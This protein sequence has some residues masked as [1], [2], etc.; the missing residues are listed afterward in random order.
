V[1]ID[2]RKNADAIDR[3]V[4]R[5]GDRLK[6]YYETSQSE[7]AKVSKIIDDNFNA[8][9][10]LVIDDASHLYE[11]TKKALDVAFP[12]L[13]VGGLYII[14]DWNWAHYNNPSFDEK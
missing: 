9:L 4:Q 13:K 5:C 2:L 10:D 11:H 12:R 3:H 1:G 7:R 8:P 6:V 14:E